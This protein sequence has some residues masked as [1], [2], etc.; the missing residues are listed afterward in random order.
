MTLEL[1]N[2]L[3]PFEIFAE[4]M[5]AIVEEIKN[6]HLSDEDGNTF[7]IEDFDLRNDED[8]D[9]NIISLPM[10]IEDYFDIWKY[11][12]ARYEEYRADCENPLMPNEMFFDVYWNNVEANS[13]FYEYVTLWI[14]FDYE[15]GIYY[16]EDEEIIEKI[17]QRDEE[18]AKA[19][20]ATRGY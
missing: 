7:R 6:E 8:G 18:L 2:Q 15:Y 1:Q 4:K 20:N 12:K 5:E 3:K 11:V 13:A 9:S 16:M 19:E 10:N 17:R 14:F